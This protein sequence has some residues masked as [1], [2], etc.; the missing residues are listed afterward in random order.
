MLHQLTEDCMMKVRAI[1]AAAVL[2][3]FLTVLP[4]L[5]VA[6]GCSGYKAHMTVM[7]S[8]EG[9]MPDATTETCVAQTTS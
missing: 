1:L 6:Q 2:A 8:A 5:T 4:A 9:T 3:P 7:S